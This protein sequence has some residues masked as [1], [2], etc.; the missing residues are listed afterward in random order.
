MKE[1]FNERV[2]SFI[3]SISKQDGTKGISELGNGIYATY[4]S[5]YELF[6]SLSIYNIFAIN[7]SGR[8]T[9]INLNDRGKKLLSLINDINVLIRQKS[10]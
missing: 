10:L 3:Y 5:K 8:E 6:E 4:K 9:I 1:L 7:D 2:V